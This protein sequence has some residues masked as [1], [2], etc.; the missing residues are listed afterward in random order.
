ML[1]IRTNEPVDSVPYGE[2]V[3]PEN[4]LKFLAQKCREVL[5]QTPGNVIEVGVYRGGTLVELA[6]VVRDVCPSNKVYGIDTFTG[7]PYDD[8]HPIHPVG[9][10]SDVEVEKLKEVFEDKGLGEWIELHKGKVEEIF[11]DLD[12]S[13]I[14]F[15]HVDCDLYTPIKFCAEHIAPL[16]K[17][18]GM[19]YF[20]D[21]GHEHCPGATQAVREVFSSDQI[22]EVALPDG[23]CWS[24]Y[25]KL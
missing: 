10:Y 25:V 12:L 23:T 7:H 1:K 2:T 14:S 9:K 24:G 13:D 5:E 4:R 18:G 16:I 6:K 19:I 8:G 15:V 22:E 17:R 20:D 21:Y 11:N 3:I